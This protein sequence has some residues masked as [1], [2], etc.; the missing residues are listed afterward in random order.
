VRATATLNASQLWWFDRTLEPRVNVG[1][2]L[3]SS[4]CS[5]VTS[6]RT[7]QFPSRLA[8]DNKGKLIALGGDAAALEGREPEG[9]HII[10]PF[11]GGF[12]SDFLAGRKLVQAGLKRARS[13]ISAAP[14]V[15][16][17]TPSSLSALE[18]ETWVALTR[19]AGASETYL[20]PQLVL[21]A[22]GAGKDVL[23]PRARFIVNIE[24]GSLE[25]GVVALGGCLLSR[26]YPGGGDM[27]TDS[28]Q[29]YVRRKHHLMID[30]GD[31]EAAKQALKTDWD[32]KAEGNHSMV[33]RLVDLG[34]PGQVFVEYQELVDLL[35]PML[36]DW[37]GHIKQAL[38]EISVDWLEDIAEDGLLLTGGGSRLAGLEGLLAKRLELPVHL[39]DQPEQ[40]VP[41]GLR[42]VVVDGRLRHGL[43]GPRSAG[44]ASED[45]QA[46]RRPRRSSL[47]AS[48]LAAIVLA[49]CFLFSASLNVPH[50]I[51]HF[52]PLSEAVFPMLDQ[53]DQA[54]DH[55][56]GQAQSTLPQAKQLE[57]QRQLDQ[58][59]NE[60]KRLWAVIH[61]PGAALERKGGEP[62]VA[63][64][65]GRDPQGWISH[66]TLDAGSN[67]GIKINQVVVS[68]G[69]LVGRISDV[70]EQISHVR[71]LLDNGSLV[72]GR[73]HG[74]HAVGLVQGVGLG[75]FEM[76]HLDPDAGVKRGDKVL[77]SGQDGRFPAGIPI[78]VVA[79]VQRQVSSTTSIAVINPAVRFS[80]VQEVL[81][82][83]TPVRTAISAAQVLA[84]EKRH[85]AHKKKA[86][87]QD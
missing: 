85:K 53:V 49:G 50:K 29:D 44:A 68:L 35:T 28:I 84:A 69:G 25:V 64:V 38:L 12:L 72:D 77:T 15:V 56:E 82:L 46:N 66:W 1:M 48:S 3:G 4:K 13:F 37:F 10:A 57:V 9:T 52:S 33:G 11:Q 2:S 16:L 19:A 27:L 18:R 51:A 79:Q 59:T 5:F 81:V 47:W 23:A 76:I 26:R 67:E 42:Q 22:L 61:R 20:C 63:R 24:G 54:E 65:V 8:L 71:P 30:R 34:Q 32:G 17:A 14:R 75:T 73:V 78:G 70:G 45:F 74:R 39:A 31:A 6:R 83:P 36:E 43:L 62:I 7:T 55:W 60:N 58:V 41:R 21:A 86:V 40:C 80:D 87:V